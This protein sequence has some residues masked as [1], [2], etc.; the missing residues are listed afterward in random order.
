MPSTDELKE[1]DKPAYDRR[2][3]NLNDD[4]SENLK[5]KVEIDEDAGFEDLSFDEDF[6]KPAFLRRQM[7]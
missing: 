1:F 6:S 4:L 3:V 7:D 5:K 2:E